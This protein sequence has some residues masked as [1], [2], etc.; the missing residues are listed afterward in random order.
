MGKE[1]EIKDWANTLKKRAKM[2]FSDVIRRV[3]TEISL[4]LTSSTSLIENSTLQTEN[5]YFVGELLP[6]SVYFTHLYLKTVLF[7]F[8]VSFIGCFAISFADLFYFTQSFFS[9]LLPLFIFVFIIFFLIFW[10]FSYKKHQKMKNIK[11]FAFF[12]DR[13]IFILS[14]CNNNTNNNNNINNAN[15][16]TNN[17]TNNANNFFNPPIDNNYN[18]NG[19]NIKIEKIRNEEITR[20]HFILPSSVSSLIPSSDHSLYNNNFNDDFIDLNINN[21]NNVNNDDDNINDIINEETKGL[22]I[23]DKEE[24]EKCLNNDNNNDNNYDDNM[25][26]RNENIIK[27]TLSKGEVIDN[28]QRGGGRCGSIEIFFF[29][30]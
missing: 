26:R 5:F 12:T 4:S 21:V 9:F 24:I 27:I 7:I 8:I 30:H 6:S 29:S 22:L 16:N 23:N 1:E 10:L 17:N 3:P 28:K 13:N 20:M 11:K 19:E 14:Y 15:N 2:S 25:H 18:Y